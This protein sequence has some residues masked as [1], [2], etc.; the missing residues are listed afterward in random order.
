M[1]LHLREWGTGPRVAVLIHGLMGDSR[2]WW[3]V[4]PALAVRGFHAVAVDLPGHGHSRRCGE[5][6]LGMLVASVLESV[7][8][9]PALAIGHSLGGGVLAL[10][11]EQLGPE[12]AAYVDVPFD[13]PT[14]KPTPESA[15]VDIDA[16]TEDLTSHYQEAKES[17]TLDHLRRIRPWWSEEDMAVEAEAARLFDV[18]TAVAMDVSG[19]IAAADRARRGVLPEPF[20]PA[21]SARSLMIRPEPSSW[22]LPEHVEELRQ[23][24]FEVRSIPGAGHSV[25]YGHLDEFMSALDSWI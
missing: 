9:A 4:G 23:M 18:T 24:G 6:S 15:D 17:R 11:A 20:R 1:K 8:A 2:C 19:A 25:W 16:L 3:E 13:P 21:G 22:V 12:R 7:S 10:A 14:W 5:A